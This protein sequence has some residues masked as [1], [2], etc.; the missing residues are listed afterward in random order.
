MHLECIGAVLQLVL[1]P[2]RG[3]RKLSRLPDRDEPCPERERD[4]CPQDEA[5]GFDRHDAAHPEPA[6]GSGHLVDRP[7]EESWIEED[8]RDV[9]EHDPRL[10]EVRDV[11]NGVADALD[12]YDRHD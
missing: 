9:L 3:R 7:S 5:S 8:R 4:G 2:L 6:K 12:G 1:D 11:A 10:W